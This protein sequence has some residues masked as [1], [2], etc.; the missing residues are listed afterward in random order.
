MPLD[1][2]SPV[3]RLAS[4]VLLPNGAL[5]RGEG[6]ALPAPITTISVSRRMD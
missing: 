3:G 1:G 5:V 4:D 2:T 6:P